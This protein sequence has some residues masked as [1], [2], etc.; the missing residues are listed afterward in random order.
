MSKTPGEARDHPDPNSTFWVT[1][2][3]GGGYAATHPQTGQ[4]P[5]D[6]E[7]SQSKVG[8]Q[9]PSLKVRAGPLRH[10]H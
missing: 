5:S 7:T 4:N 2:A 6:P 1:G 3:S 10:T 8:V 9:R